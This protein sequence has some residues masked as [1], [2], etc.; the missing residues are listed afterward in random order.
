MFHLVELLASAPILMHLCGMCGRWHYPSPIP[1]QFSVC[2]FMFFLHW[3]AG[4]SMFHFVELF[5]QVLPCDV[6]VQDC[7]AGSFIP[8]PSH[9]S[10]SAC[11]LCSF[12]V[13]LEVPFHFTL[14]S[15]QQVLPLHLHGV[16]WDGSFTLPHPILALDAFC[17][18]FISL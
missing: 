8:P 16:V 5:W 13:G 14:S 6:L 1:F 15:F 10:F 12:Y 17:M 9:F 2:F 4:Y 18:F 11:F 3:S 7:V